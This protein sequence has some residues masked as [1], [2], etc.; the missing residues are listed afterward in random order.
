M[1]IKGVKA[2]KIL[3]SR[4]QETIEIIVDSD[5]LQGIGSAPSGAS[6]S[7]KEVK[8]FP[9]GADGAVEFVNNT[10]SKDLANFS[11]EKFEDFKKIEKIISKYDKSKD[12]SVIGGNLIV[13]LEFAIL[14][15]FKQ[16]WKFL[17]PEAK[18]LPRPL[19]NVIGGGAHVKEGIDY[20]EFL[21]LSLN[22]PSIKKAIEA[23]FDIHKSAR[24]K[25]GLFFNTM[26]ASLSQKSDIGSF[27]ID[28]TNKFGIFSAGAS[29]DVFKKTFSNASQVGIEP[30]LGARYTLNNTTLKLS[31]T[32]ISV[33]DNQHWTDPIIGVRIRYTINKAWLAL[34]AGDVG[35]TNFN[36]HNSYNVNAFV[37]YKPQTI[38]KNTTF[39][40]GY[41]LLYQNYVTGSG[42][43]RFAWDMKLLG[44]AAGV[45]I[46]L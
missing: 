22:A 42:S 29:Y 18:Q 4:G 9:K 27:T 24:R 14:N 6:K 41:R 15:C 16:P 21:L 28:S 8:D 43:G 10:L 37:G 33:S 20:Q 13:A 26:Y 19:G 11:F 31:G 45:A 35:G 46:A 40:V 17:N 34:V 30:Y 3:N 39:Y 1:I 2:R 7:S 36:N 38:L 12:L 25:F 5:I 32:T 44:P 23:N